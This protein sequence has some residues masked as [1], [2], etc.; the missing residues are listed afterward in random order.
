MRLPI[1]LSVVVL[2]ILAVA[3]AIVAYVKDPAFR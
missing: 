2:T 3:M 1:D